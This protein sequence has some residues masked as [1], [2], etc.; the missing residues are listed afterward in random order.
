MFSGNLIIQSNNTSILAGHNVRLSLWRINNSASC[1]RCNNSRCTS[2]SQV[3]QG[4]CLL[5][6]AYYCRTAWV[7]PQHC[8]NSTT[9]HWEKQTAAAWNLGWSLMQTVQVIV[10]SSYYPHI[11]PPPAIVGSAYHIFCG[12]PYGS[13][14]PESAPALQTGISTATS[15][16][17]HPSQLSDMY[18]S[19]E[20]DSMTLLLVDAT[21][22]IAKLEPQLEWASQKKEELNLEIT[23]LHDELVATFSML[24][25][26]EATPVALAHDDHLGMSTSSKPTFSIP[27]Q[28]ASPFPLLP[29]ELSSS[30]KA[31]ALPVAHTSPLKSSSFSK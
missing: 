12:C 17:P 14:V 18:Y 28:C 13:L 19:K 6:T 4:Q 8:Q 11:I 20:P 2:S 10:P 29:V 5:A 27:L 21:R 15:I 25:T 7:P 24:H 1:G 26:Q 23:N 30:G 16:T 31:H 3:S 9:I 22:K